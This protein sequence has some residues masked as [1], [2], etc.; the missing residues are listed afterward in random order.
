MN[1][2]YAPKK[3]NNELKFSI[4]NDKNLSKYFFYIIFYFLFIILFII[5]YSYIYFYFF[6]KTA[7]IVAC[8]ITT[9]VMIAFLILASCLYSN[10]INEF[11]NKQNLIITIHQSKKEH[12][13]D[14]EKLFQ[15]SN[16]FSQ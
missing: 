16:R 3:L 10:K 13:D 5:A 12:N 2:P 8:I 11:K 6:Y 7:F 1:N 15:M 4:F 9:I 14:F